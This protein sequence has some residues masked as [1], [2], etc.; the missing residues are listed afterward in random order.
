[1]NDLYWSLIMRFL[2]NRNEEIK[3]LVEMLHKSSG[4]IINRSTGKMNLDLS[5]PD[6]RKKITDKAKEFFNAMKKA[7]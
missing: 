4:I 3:K 2:C 7:G 1:M 5:N 6:A